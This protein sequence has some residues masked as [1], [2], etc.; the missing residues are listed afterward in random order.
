[1]TDISASLR[2]EHS[3]KHLHEILQEPIAVL[4]GVSDSAVAALGQSGVVSVFD[5]GSSRLFAQTESVLSYANS[6]L[7]VLPGD[8]LKSTVEL[9]S[10]NQAPRLSLESLN[11]LTNIAAQALKSALDIETIQ[12]FSQWPPRAVAKRLVQE[13]FGS[14]TLT[15]ED[16]QAEKLRPKFGEYPTERVYY[17]TLVMF[18]STDNQGQTPFAGP[19]SLQ[20]SA[21][22]PGGFSQPAI[23]AL[24]SWSQ[25]WFAQ[26]ITLGHMLHSLA[27]APGEATRIAVVDWSRRSRAASTEAIDESEQL[28]NAT[29]HSRAISEVQNA[30]ADEMQSGGSMASGWAKSKSKSK[31]ISG[32]IGGGVAGIGYGV[33]GV[34]GFGG[35]AP[36]PNRRPSLLPSPPAPPGPSVQSP[37][38]RK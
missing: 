9:A 18:G 15:I 28:D 38:W 8:L 16:A 6:A 4:L 1:M 11:G 17:D 3:E 13:A 34:L 2:S 26:G 37:S 7:D 27:L 19:I 31:G 22:N 29:D 36:R 10:P 25:S 24:T 20:P 32:S 33:A 23:G 12:D 21:A 14:E 5:L 35:G 30:V